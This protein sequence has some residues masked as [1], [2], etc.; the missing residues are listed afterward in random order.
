MEPCAISLSLMA[1]IKNNR[2]DS[3]QSD[4]ITFKSKY[5]ET[6][7]AQAHDYICI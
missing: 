2:D 1:Y 5:K 7:K 3:R 6:Y 4:I